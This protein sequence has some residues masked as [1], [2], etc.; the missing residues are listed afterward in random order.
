MKMS[1]RRKIA[2]NDKYL[3]QEECHQDSSVW[4]A[5]KTKMLKEEVD[6]Q[7]NKKI[8]ARKEKVKNQWNAL[9]QWYERERRYTVRKYFLN[10]F[11]KFDLTK[12]ALPLYRL[13]LNQ[14]FLIKYL[15]SSLIL[16]SK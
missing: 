1:I 10:R 4:N 16:K 5:N 13:T 14:Q 12:M 7:T 3:K 2:Q 8:N 15:N 9:S 11:T 6:V